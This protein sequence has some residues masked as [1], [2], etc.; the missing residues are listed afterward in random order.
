MRNAPSGVGGVRERGRHNEKKELL[1][2]AAT[3]ITNLDELQKTLIEAVRQA[4]QSAG[5]RGW[6][7]Q[8]MVVLLVCMILYFAIDK[9]FTYKRELRLG[10]RITVL[11]DF[12]HGKL[13]EVV[14][15][16]AVSLEK[17]L[18]VISSLENTLQNRVCLLD[19]T[20][21]DGF[22]NRVGDR[23]A[24]RVADQFRREDKDIRRERRNNEVDN[25]PP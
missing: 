13:L 15:I 23:V 14:Q 4:S 20:Q 21:Q 1:M 10:N 9:W 2:L 24:E 5:S 16:N 11:E 12:A 3:T 7:A 17:V 19:Y 18:G 8:M 22:V 6:E 25:A